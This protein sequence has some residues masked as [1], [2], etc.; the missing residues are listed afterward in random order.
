[1]PRDSVATRIDVSE[2]KRI[3][4]P[5]LSLSLSRTKS[6]HSHVLLVCPHRR[7]SAQAPT[8]ST[9]STNSIYCTVLSLSQLYI[10]IKHSLYTIISPP[11]SPCSALAGSAGTTNPPW[12]ATRSFPLLRRA[13]FFP[14]CLSH[15]AALLPQMPTNTSA[16]WSP[17]LSHIPCLPPHATASTPNHPPS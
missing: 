1:M 7:D 13:A 14:S 4:V 3:A 2:K 9:S 10:Q 17:S 11:S 12:P 5:A 15:S 16:T 6:H 8:T